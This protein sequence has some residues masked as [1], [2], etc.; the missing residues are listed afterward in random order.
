MVSQ[1]FTVKRRESP[2][3]LCSL[4]IQNH[5]NSQSSVCLTPF[6]PISHPYAL[7]HPHC[8]AIM[9]SQLF[10][11]SLLQRNFI[12]F[13]S[14]PLSTLAKPFPN[15]CRKP[16]KSTGSWPLLNNVVLFGNV[17]TS[18]LATGVKFCEECSRCCDFS[19]RAFQCRGQGVQNSHVVTTHVRKPKCRISASH[20]EICSWI[21]LF[22][23]GF[24]MS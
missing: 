20:N 23:M 4:L 7:T 9:A 16:H 19:V 12:K 13:T 22:S 21:S 10:S 17:R 24:K 6:R 8:A 15:R 18:G 11:M 5:D 2:F 3:D 1:A 14:A